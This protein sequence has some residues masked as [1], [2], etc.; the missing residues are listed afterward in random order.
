MIR[1]LCV[2]GLLWVM[3][4][5]HRADRSPETQPQAPCPEQTL[6]SAEV[7]ELSRLGVITVDA[8]RLGEHHSTA[9]L[10]AGMPMLKKAALHGDGT[11]M[12]KYASLVT[13]YGFIDNDGEPFLGRS[14]GENGQE[15]LLFSLLAA[16]RGEPIWHEDQDNF[17]VLL[18]PAVPFPAGF[19]E[20]GSG[21]AWLV[22][23]WSPESV[24]QVRQ[25]AYGW[26]D[27]WPD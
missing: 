18:D 12:A 19:F 6:S 22:Q 17:R 13:W 1:W 2:G 24:D 11:A 27:C 7:A 3:G 4:C 16:H 5:A 15:G 23:G 21:I 9:S 26:R 20:D 14:Q 25:E 8:N 10:E